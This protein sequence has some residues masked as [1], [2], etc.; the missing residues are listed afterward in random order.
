M[1][2]VLAFAT[3]LFAYDNKEFFDTVPP[4]KDP[5]MTGRKYKKY[6]EGLRKSTEKKK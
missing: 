5:R 2:F 3:A 1:V 6:L 4:H